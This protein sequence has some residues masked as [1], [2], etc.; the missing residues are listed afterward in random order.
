M[1]S[2][3]IKLAVAGVL[4][5]QTL[6][7]SHAPL[8]DALVISHMVTPIEL[9]CEAGNILPKEECGAVT[10]LNT[11]GSETVPDSAIV[12]S[13]DGRTHEV[14]LLRDPQREKAWKLDMQHEAESL[15]AKSCKEQ[16][17]QGG[18]HCMFP[19]KEC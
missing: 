13:R 12:F 4:K 11:G 17:C 18:E 15:L 3:S 6:E 10:L 16:G 9:A 1:S 5:T 2:V 14:T 7:G 19:N 8:A